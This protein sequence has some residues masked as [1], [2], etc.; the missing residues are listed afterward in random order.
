MVS[1]ASRGTNK[2]RV[3]FPLVCSVIFAIDSE[4]RLFL[5][6]HTSTVPNASKT[7]EASLG[8]RGNFVLSHLISVKK[9][10]YRNTVRV[11]K[12]MYFELWSVK[13]SRKIF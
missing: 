5:L 7:R 2:L 3:A 1:P 13:S 6:I 4:M 10:K 11:A 8:G 12:R 9:K